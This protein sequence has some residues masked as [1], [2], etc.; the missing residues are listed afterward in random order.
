MCNDKF[1]NPNILQL[2]APGLERKIKLAYF[3]MMDHNPGPVA[4]IFKFCIDAVLYLAAD[5]DNKIA[6]HCKAGKGRTGLVISA[7]FIFTE[8]SRTAQDAVNLFNSRR[9]TNGKGLGIA[10]QVRYIT[11]FYEFLSQFKRPFVQTIAPYLHSPKAFDDMLLAKNRL[12]LMTVCLGPFTASPT[13]LD[14]KLQ[15]RDFVQDTLFKKKEDGL[16]EK[17]TF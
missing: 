13:G 16:F 4:I 8:Q 12:K 1:V 6:V 3:P 15:A 5:P 9:T 11:Y 2:D 17:V 14:I 7:Y 10:S